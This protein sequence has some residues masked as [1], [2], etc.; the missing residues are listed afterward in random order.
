M[1]V[2]RIFANGQDVSSDVFRQYYVQRGSVA[3]LQWNTSIYTNNLIAGSFLSPDAITASGTVHAFPKYRG[4]F[5][6]Y[7]YLQGKPHCSPIESPVIRELWGIHRDFKVSAILLY[8]C[9]YRAIGPVPYTT[10]KYRLQYRNANLGES[11]CNGHKL[12]FIWSVK[13]K[14]R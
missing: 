1:Y 3:A 4:N 8:L 11:E 5:L 6:E 7:M 10:L 12:D 14:V 13:K 9:S 2:C